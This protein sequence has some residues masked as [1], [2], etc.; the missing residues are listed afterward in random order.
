MSVFW[1]PWPSMTK[2]TRTP[3]PESAAVLRAVTLTVSRLPISWGHSLQE[4]GGNDVLS[5]KNPRTGGY[6]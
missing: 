4:T 6:R 2:A 1:K 3:G 5:R